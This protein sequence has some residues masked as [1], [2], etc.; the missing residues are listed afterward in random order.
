[1][2]ADL[3]DVK[4]GDTLMYGQSYN[5]RMVVVERLTDTQIICGN[6]RF[7]KHDGKKI[8]S[9]GWDASFARVPNDADLQE[10]R[11]KELQQWFVRVA[12]TQ[13]NKHLFEQLR[14]DLKE[15]ENAG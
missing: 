12:V 14:T 10:L 5:R 8:A 2:I 13:A 3:K 6:V 9:N 1:M 15:L 11:F 7:R 4:V